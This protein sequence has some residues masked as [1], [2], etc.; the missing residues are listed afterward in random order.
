ME[1]VGDEKLIAGMRAISSGLETLTDAPKRSA[2]LIADDARSFAPKLTGRLARS[3]VGRSDRGRLEVGT[4]IEYGL[5]VHFGVPSRN[6]GAKPFLHKA[7]A[8]DSDAV[9]VLWAKDVQSLI[10]E[11]L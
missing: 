8:M 5:P 7:L 1:L 6:I 11:E 9:L 2:Q 3:I 4:P 10:D